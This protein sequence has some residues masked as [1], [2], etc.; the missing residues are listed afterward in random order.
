MTDN[1]QSDRIYASEPQTKI[2]KDPASRFVPLSDGRVVRFDPA[3]DIAGLPLDEMPDPAAVPIAELPEAPAVPPPSLIASALPGDD[4][5]S[6]AA[7]MVDQLRGQYSEM[8][9]RE[10]AFASQ[11]QQLEEERRSLRLWKQEAENE[12]ASKGEELRQRETALTEQGAKYYVA[13][14]QLQA[15]RLEI[16]RQRE[17]LDADRN[18]MMLE[19]AQRVAAERERL[20]N[21]LEATESERL[22]LQG[23]FDRRKLSLE[24]DLQAQRLE[25][26]MAKSRVRQDV[27]EEILTAE[28][29][30]DRDSLL[31][32]RAEF[33]ELRGDWTAQRERER[34]ELEHERQIQNEAVDRLR[35]ELL[36]QRQQQVQALDVERTEHSERLQQAQIDFDSQREQQL[37]ELR[38]ERAVLE[39]R[40][41]FQQEHLTKAR[42]EIETAQN[43]FR[44]ESERTRSQLEE[45]ESI[46]RMRQQQL[47][48]VRAL[49][50]ERERSVARE[51]EMLFKSQQAFEQ[52][53]ATD[54]EAI[55]AEREEWDCERSMQLTDLRRQQDMLALHVQ[56][57]EGRRERLDKLRSELEETHR[58]SLE[59]R[60]AIEEAWAQI[61]QAVG[62][63][64]AKQRVD[65]AQQQLSSHYRALRESLIEQ[66]AEL[67]ELSEQ[68]VR[69]KDE[70]RS[71]QQTLTEFAT[72]QDRQIRERESALR[73]Q[74]E[75]LDLRESAW[76][77]ASHRWI[78]EKIE[79]EAIIRDLLQQLTSLTEPASPVTMWPRHEMPAYE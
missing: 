22:R 24:A 33:V 43:E 67:D 47:D 4:L 5:L 74:A 32:E 10:Q 14:D 38:H 30:K 52:C 1:L 12:L 54:R 8:Q 60:M 41:R 20:Q 79:A 35:E 59:L 53:T 73:L 57:L 44:R 61:T 69:Q 3:Q 76:K 9:R 42:Q 50:E 26:E 62:Q 48:R 46:L 77:S 56:N 27:T 51:R 36:V 65:Q 37:I 66:R 75:Q 17:L 23:D 28:L 16:D 78:N 72:Q 64:T 18:R 29:R 63:D 71:E 40:L 21:A 13:V 55:K 31:R 7:K 49:L 70:F 25:V 58:N 68:I 19:I 11:S 2:A 15:Q 6:H 34:A 45:S 39:N